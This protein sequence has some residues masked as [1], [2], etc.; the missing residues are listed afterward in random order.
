MS[1]G[2]R[3]QF[4]PSLM[5]GVMLCLNSCAAVNYSFCPIYPL[6]GA[7]VASELEHLSAEEYPDTWEWIGRIDKLRQ[8]LEICKQTTGD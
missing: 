6:A 4:M 2:K 1:D 5:L 8:E 7:D 3:P